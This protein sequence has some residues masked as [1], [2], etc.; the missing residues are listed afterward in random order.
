MTKPCVQCVIVDDERLARKHLVRLLAPHPDFRIAG[1]AANA[2]EALERIADLK[3][4]VAFLDIEM[5]GLNAFDMLA[6]LSEP[7]LVVFTTAYDEYAIQLSI[8]TRSITFSNR[9]NRLV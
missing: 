1:E 4:D 2:I 3:P 8:R 6:Q 7:P 9:F 5:P